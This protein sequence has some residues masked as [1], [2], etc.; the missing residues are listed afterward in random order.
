MIIVNFHSILNNTGEN[1]CGV[2]GVEYR[3]GGGDE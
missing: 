3:S 1:S 2:S